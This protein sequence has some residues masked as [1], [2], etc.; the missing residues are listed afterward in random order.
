MPIK[1][2]VIQNFKELIICCFQTYNF[3]SCDIIFAVLYFRGTPLLTYVF[4]R[5][6][7]VLTKTSNKLSIRNHLKPPETIQELSETNQETTDITWNKAENNWYPLKWAISCKFC[8]RIWN[9][10]S[11]TFS[12]QSNLTSNQMDLFKILRRQIIGIINIINVVPMSLLLT[13]TVIS[14]CS[15]ARSCS[16]ESHALY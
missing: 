5:S 7:Y 8:S 6:V 13:L 3:S 9:T 12:E 1:I 2:S 10:H 15:S 16:T 4:Y 11:W 14:T